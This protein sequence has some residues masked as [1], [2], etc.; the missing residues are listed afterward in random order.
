MKSSDINIF[1]IDRLFSPD[2]FP[3]ADYRQISNF[4]LDQLIDA[5]VFFK[6]D[7]PVDWASLD[8]EDKKLT[9]LAN[10]FRI[11]EINDAVLLQ[12]NKER[13]VLINSTL[14]EFFGEKFG[15]N[16]EAWLAL[17]RNGEVYSEF[18]L[19]KKQDATLWA[20]ASYRFISDHD[21][22]T[23]GILLVQRDISQRKIAFRA[24]E[25]TE[26]RLRKLAQLSFQ[27]IVILNHGKVADVNDAM[28]KITGY[29]R[30]ELLNTQTLASCFSK[31]ISA[32]IFRKTWEVSSESYEDTLCRKDRTLLQVEIE[33][34]IMAYQDEPAYVIGI[35]DISNRKKI[36]EE[37]VK[38]SIALDQSANEIVIT[39]K[40]GDIEYVNRS[41]TNVTGYLPSEVIGRNPRIL[42]SGTQSRIL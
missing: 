37:I 2:P 30:D 4:L 21:G 27:A 41:F 18:T 15:E 29:D 5:F 8:T 9:T 22:K 10:N 23:M 7:K 40:D 26:E 16:R 31:K 13:N 36:E 42:K 39:R 1:N 11:I 3:G 17:I 14:N 25:E 33:T 28:L 35:S 24:H 34:Q 20:E 19:E 12:S 6:A 32:K 38:L